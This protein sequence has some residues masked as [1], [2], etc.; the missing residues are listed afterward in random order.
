MVR[1]AFHPDALLEYAHA[2]NYYLGAASPA[3]AERF[4]AAVESAVALI[5]ADPERCR[6]AEEPGI[7][8]FVF[9]R[10]P[11]VLYYRWEAN[12]EF[13]SI[14]AVMHCSREPGYWKQRI[15]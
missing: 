10:F 11:Y 1:F 15:A 8:R 13:V 6:I 5:V 9:R 14:F 7:R 3:I 12:R 4:I 2:T